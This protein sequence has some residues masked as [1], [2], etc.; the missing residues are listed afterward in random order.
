MSIECK[1]E[2]SQGIIRNNVF[3]DVFEMSYYI[4]RPIQNES[5]MNF[6]LL[7]I[8]HRKYGG[9]LCQNKIPLESSS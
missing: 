6:L 9:E 8:A 1:N 7:S 3:N 4:V 5:P 2:V